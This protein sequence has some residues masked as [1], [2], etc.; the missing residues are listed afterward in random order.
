MKDKEKKNILRNNPCTS[1]KVISDFEKLDVKLKKLGV[2]TGSKYN[3]HQ[4]LGEKVISPT[5]SSEFFSKRNQ[6]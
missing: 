3:L 6:S 1:K 2:N 4:P 5:K